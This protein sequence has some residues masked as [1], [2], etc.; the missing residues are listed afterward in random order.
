MPR[1]RGG[2]SPCKSLL[3]VMN[4]LSV[5]EENEDSFRRHS[6]DS[7]S[8][9]DI[10]QECFGLTVRHLAVLGCICLH[11]L[12]PHCGCLRLLCQWTARLHPALEPNRQTQN[13]P[14]EMNK[15]N[16]YQDECMHEY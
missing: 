8:P 2:T 13:M 4:Q 12:R 14:V 3:S 9:F 16:I 6:K 1:G 5:R 15:L 7:R 10:Y 11:F